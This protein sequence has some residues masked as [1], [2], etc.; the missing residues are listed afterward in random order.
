MSKDAS[1]NL[2]EQK[3]VSLT[4]F[5]R[6][7]DAVA[8][9]MWIVA[10]GDQLWAWTPADAWKVKRIRRDP[11]VTLTACGRRGNVQPGAPVIDATA[12][13]ITDAGEVTRVESLIKRKYGL[14]FRIV[15]LIE[16]IAARGRKPRFAVRITV[17]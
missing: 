1:P 12:E 15:T 3:F 14:E 16:T 4:T 17:A 2:G 5:K 9:P 8:S 7:G 11:R 13:V 6:N 10:E